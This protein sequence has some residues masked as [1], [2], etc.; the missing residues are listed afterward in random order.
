MTKT[1]IDGLGGI[2]HSPKE[3]TLPGQAGLPARTSDVLDV[4]RNE[5]DAETPTGTG[6]DHKDSM[7]AKQPPRRR[8]SPD[9]EPD[10]TS[11]TDVIE[12]IEGTREDNPTN[13]NF[14]IDELHHRK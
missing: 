6:W 1:I 13:E 12:I 9:L 4:P 3:E 2:S 11:A 8:S 14:L 5:A 10:T 7:A